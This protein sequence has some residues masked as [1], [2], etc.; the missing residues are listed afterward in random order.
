MDT[1]LTLAEVAIAMA[2]LW[3]RLQLLGFGVVVVILQG[4][5]ALSAFPGHELALYLIGV[6]WHV[7]QAAVLFV[8][9]IWI[10]T[11]Q[12]EQ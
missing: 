10:P 1:L 9:L 11:S 12:I 3:V 7:M 4:A 2:G 6:F 8:M 5:N